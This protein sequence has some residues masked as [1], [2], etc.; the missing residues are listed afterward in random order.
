MNVT[1]MLSLLGATSFI[2]LF[3][4]LIKSLAMIKSSK[5]EK[6]IM[7]DQQRITRGILIVS[8]LTLI[9]AVAFGIWIFFFRNPVS[10]N[11]I[12]IQFLIMVV[13]G[14]IIFTITMYPSIVRIN[15]N[16]FLKLENRKYYIIKSTSTGE[17][18]LS[19]TPKLYSEIIL[20]KREDLYNKTIYQERS[21]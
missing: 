19:T 21:T 11:Y 20:I 17:I 15:Y 12:M 9:N 5:F 7:N 8:Y 16:F 4:M 1:A 10:W 3:G 2:A 14:I 13:F 6:I 18:I